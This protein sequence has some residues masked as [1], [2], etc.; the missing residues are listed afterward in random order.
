MLYQVAL[1]DELRFMGSLSH[2]CIFVSLLT[3]ES[4]PMWAYTRSGQRQL[5]LNVR[6]P[7]VSPHSWRSTGME[8]PHEG[9]S[10]KERFPQT[11]V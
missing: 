9:T 11:Y 10:Q 2:P 7:K 8:Q 5:C 3:S 6:I 1:R 4:V